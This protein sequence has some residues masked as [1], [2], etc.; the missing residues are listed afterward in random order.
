METY[1]KIILSLLA[2]SY[3][4]FIL[5]FIVL[6]Q[7]HLFSQSLFFTFGGKFALLGVTFQ[8]QTFYVG[9]CFFF[10]FTSLVGQ[11]NTNIVSPVF[12]RLIFSH[13]DEDEHHGNG[14]G[15]S[16][17]M[18]YFVLLAYDLWSVAR[19]LFGLLGILSNFG[20]FI[21]TSLGYLVGDLA[22][23]YVYIN[24]PRVLNFE[25]KGYRT[26][27]MNSAGAGA[28]ASADTESDQEQRKRFIE[29]AISKFKF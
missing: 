11:L 16:K 15:L 10:F 8:N 4:L 21:A 1:L 25:S 7:Q 20:F 12:S 17:S 6:S 13:P 19:S 28:G 5:M 24:W 27:P 3:V 18:L 22:V 26:I 23:K 14:P 9:L 29:S 2:V